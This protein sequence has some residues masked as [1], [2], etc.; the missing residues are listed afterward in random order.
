MQPEQVMIKQEKSIVKVD[1]QHIEK[2]DIS[3]VLEEAITNATIV[4]L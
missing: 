3:S 4:T 1:M 2:I